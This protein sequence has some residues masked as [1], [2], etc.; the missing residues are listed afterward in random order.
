MAKTLKFNSVQAYADLSQAIKKAADALIREYFSE[1]YSKLDTIKGREALEIM[2]EDEENFLRRKVIGY[3]DAIMD[4][5]GTGS[6]MDKSNPALD[7]YM[8]SD[9]WNSLR[10]GLS[11]VGREKGTYKD[12]YGKTE[13]SKGTFAGMDLEAIKLVKPK[14]PSY[15]F[16]QADT[17]FFGG[18]RVDEVLTAAIKKFFRSENMKKYFI[19]G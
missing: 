1:V 4:S 11:I 6:K 13:Y 14:A 10:V 15:A 12:I 5:Y 8:D 2:S 19:F 17:W 3:A 18:N 7:D 9:M 16:Q